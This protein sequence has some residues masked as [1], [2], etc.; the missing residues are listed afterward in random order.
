MNA[1][2]EFVQMQIFISHYNGAVDFG[3]ARADGI[4]G[5]IHKGTQSTNYSDPNYTANPTKAVS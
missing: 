2:H 4:I 5:V 3:Q 1:R